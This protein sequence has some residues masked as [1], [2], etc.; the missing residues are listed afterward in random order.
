MYGRNRLLDWTNSFLS[1]PIIDRRGMETQEL[2]AG[3]IAQVTDY[4]SNNVIHD[5]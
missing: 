4:R 2:R 5:E 3:I 1:C